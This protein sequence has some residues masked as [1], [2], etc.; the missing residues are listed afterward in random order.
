MEFYICSQ[1]SKAKGL[2][3]P[4]CFYAIFMLSASIPMCL[5]KV[6]VQVLL[7][8]SVGILLISQALHNSANVQDKEF[9]TTFVQPFKLMVEITLEMIMIKVF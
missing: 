6:R 2:K 3:Q 5:P 9:S 1:V 8:N 7:M 4:G